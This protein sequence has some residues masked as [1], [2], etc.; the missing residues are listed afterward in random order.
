MDVSEDCGKTWQNRSNGLAATM[1]YD[2]DVAQDDGRNFGGGAQDNGTVV[3]ATGSAQEYFMVLGGDGG[4]MVYDPQNA[5]H[6]YASFYNMGIFRFAN[7]EWTDVSPPAGDQEKQAV[8]M[9]YIT[10]DPSNPQTVCT[11]SF[12]LWRTTGDG[13][14][15]QAISPSFDGSA[16]SAIE[17]APADP[18]RIYVG[19]ENGG[20]FR[21]TDG[22]TTWSANLSSS[23]LPGFIITRLETSAKSGADLLY[24]TV[25]NFDKAHAFRSRDGGVTWEDI[26]KGQLPNVPHHAILL[27]P[28]NPSTVYVCNDVGVFA[29][30]DG[31]DTWSN[32]TSNL[33]NVMIIDLVYQ[34]TDQMLYAAT[35]GRS[36]WRIKG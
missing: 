8:W 11:G 24:A 14:T 30:Q 31:G 18:K 26:D 34:S 19:T 7:G 6:V 3:T 1:F 12:R 27:V 36:I 5:R 25:G 13:A 9:C 4:W 10:M 23:V 28:D 22:G 32:M 29:S 33:P 16:I 17:V 35:Y 20:F 2:M 15:W 21:S